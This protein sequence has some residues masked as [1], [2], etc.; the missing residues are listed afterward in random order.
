[1]KFTDTETKIFNLLEPTID[2]MGFELVLINIINNEPKIVKIIIDGKNG[3][4]LTIDD[5][6]KVSKA[7]APIFDVEDMF[8]NKYVLEVSSAGIERP[9]VKL[10]DYLKFIDRHV[11]VKLHQSLDGKKI[12]QGLLMSI[13]ND[14]IILQVQDIKVIMQKKIDFDNIKAA[15][16][17][18]T[19]EMFK[20]ILKN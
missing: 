10:A 6:K 9:L 16:L 11:L 8:L 18:L 14:S 1:M 20:E 7:I 3:V 15:N 2:L 13:E 12:Y 17:V 5:C 19:Q 4:K